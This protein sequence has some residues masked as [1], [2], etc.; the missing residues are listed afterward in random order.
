MQLIMESS[1]NEGKEPDFSKLAGGA[2]LTPDSAL[3]LSLFNVK[4]ITTMSGIRAFDMN[5]EI[6]DSAKGPGGLIEM[7]ATQKI[8]PSQSTV[9]ETVSNEVSKPKTPAKTTPRG[10]GR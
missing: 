10:P 7:L 2:K 8:A 9:T 1:Q 4:T 3:T 6:A 5:H